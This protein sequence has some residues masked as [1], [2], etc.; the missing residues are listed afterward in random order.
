MLPWLNATSALTLAVLLGACGEHV[1]LGQFDDGPTNGP[2]DAS[3]TI[4]GATYAKDA[5][6]PNN[7]CEQVC[8]PD[9]STTDWSTAHQSSC[10]TDVVSGAAN[11]C[12]LAD[13]VA[14]CWGGNYLSGGAAA[15]SDRP[16]VVEGLPS[17]VT[18]ISV[19]WFGGRFC[20]VAQDQVYCWGLDGHGGGGNGPLGDGS[21]AVSTRPVAVQGL[22]ANVTAVTTSSKHSCAIA[23][24]AVYCWGANVSGQL[25]DG[26]FI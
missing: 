4:A 5:R 15:M 1:P 6:N 22:P 9:V 21:T 3:C 2:T 7:A 17:G 25:G 26:T 10:V 23:N 14:Y 8:L 20:A 18:A 11:T 13:G 16:Q 12:A 24:G 19:D